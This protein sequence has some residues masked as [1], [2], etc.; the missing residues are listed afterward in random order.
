MARNHQGLN[1]MGP[2][3]CGSLLGPFP[4]LQTRAAN[5]F[6]TAMIT[7]LSS[8]IPT[9]YNF[10]AH[11]RATYDAQNA[12]SYYDTD[13]IDLISELTELTDDEA[14][15]V[16]FD[17]YEESDKKPRVFGP[18]E[19]VS[20]PPSAASDAHSHNK[21]AI[22]RKLAKATQ[23]LPSAASLQ[24]VVSSS[25]PVQTNYDP[26]NAPICKGAYR[27][28]DKR[29]NFKALDPKRAWKVG[30]LL[31]ANKHLRLVRYYEGCV[32]LSSSRCISSPSC[33]QATPILD[34]DGQVIAFRSSPPTD[35][36]WARDMTAAYGAVVQI[37]ENGKVKV[38]S[39]CPRGAH[40]SIHFG[41]SCGN[42]VGEIHDLKLGS[43]QRAIEAFCAEK[44][45]QRLRAHN[46]SA[47][48]ATTCEIRRTN[49][50]TQVF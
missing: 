22:K 44:A 37:A 9:R 27:S 28:R 26:D 5:D 36:S 23:T 38:D 30:D 15:Q 11:L 6:T 21:R 7:L 25:K 20:R 2:D 17:V 43:Q 32:I 41:L 8:C 49:R 33:R 10:A 14:D 19:C 1:A 48:F 35:P 34:R 4:T 3:G 18:S 47:R 45:I 42:G 29:S 40:A 12:H 13:C 31:D 24:R 50:L 46:K 16:E 39:S